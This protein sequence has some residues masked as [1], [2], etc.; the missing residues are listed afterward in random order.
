MPHTDTARREW[1]AAPPTGDP[2][3]LAP[4]GPIDKS[5]AE[6]LPH[7]AR[8]DDVARQT[9]QEHDALLA[10]MHRLEA[11][12]AAAAPGR[13]RA[14]NARVLED[15]RAVRACLARHVESAEAPGGF[16]A[17]V[18]LTRPT[19]A[20]RVGRLRREHADLLHLAAAFQRQVEHHGP[21]ERPDFADIR[22]RATGLLEALRQHQ[23]QEADLIFETFFVDI[24]AGD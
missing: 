14:W 8:Q 9:R 12:L 7:P 2:E 20:R 17:E 24:G 23:A 3:P 18:D 11:A 1:P 19:L 21:D 10:A 22:R 16:F 6:S 4:V 13:E 15:L 5:L